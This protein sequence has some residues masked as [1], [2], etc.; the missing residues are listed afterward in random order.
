MHRRKR[1]WHWTQFPLCLPICARVRCTRLI[2]YR[3]IFKAWRGALFM[4]AA[5]L[6]RTVGRTIKKHAKENLEHRLLWCSNRTIIRTG[7]SDKFEQIIPR[8]TNSGRWWRSLMTQPQHINSPTSLASIAQ[9]YLG[10]RTSLFATLTLCFQRN[11][12]K[13]KGYMSTKKHSKK[14][15]W[16]ER[17]WRGEGG[18]TRGESGDGRL[19][20]FAKSK[21][22]LLASVQLVVSPSA[23]RLTFFFA[24]ATIC[25]S[26][27]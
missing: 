8:S 12:L 6:P 16:R 14:H 21:L 4:K 17:R 23:A 18:M 5:T 19:I 27:H 15:K 24:Y 22:T 10:A 1:V 26:L 13:L 7:M 25:A 20:Y 3:F 2:T 9:H 11:T